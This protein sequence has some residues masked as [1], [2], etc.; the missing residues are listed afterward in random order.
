MQRNLSFSE[1]I[2]IESKRTIE[3]DEF[4]PKKKIEAI[5]VEDMVA[6]WTSSLHIA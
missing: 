1:A 5:S 6:L 4:V 2:A 3:I